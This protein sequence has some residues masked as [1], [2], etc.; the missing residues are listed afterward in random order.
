MLR[1][2]RVWFQENEGGGGGSCATYI[3][4]QDVEDGLGKPGKEGSR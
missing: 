1:I 2:K 3:K 4:R